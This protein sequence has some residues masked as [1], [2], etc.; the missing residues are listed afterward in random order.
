MA[1]PCKNGYCCLLDENDPVLGP[2]RGM[3]SLTITPAG[4]LSGFRIRSF[5]SS[6]VF[7][8]TLHQV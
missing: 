3:N 1:V 7:N 5:L 6:H 2:R 4:Q 8:V